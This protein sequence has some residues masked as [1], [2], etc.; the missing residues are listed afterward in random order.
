M[1]AV[2]E[3][4]ASMG[5][6]VAGGT[7][8]EFRRYGHEIIDYIAGYRKSLPQMPVWSSLRADMHSLSHVND[9]ND[10]SDRLGQ[11]NGNR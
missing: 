5:L 11:R 3:R 9:S 7:P 10:S 2:A 4:L 1:P 8:D 6:S